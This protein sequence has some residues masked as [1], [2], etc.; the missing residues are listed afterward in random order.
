LEACGN[1]HAVTEDVVAID[2]DVA[3]VDAGA[4]GDAAIPPERPPLSPPSPSVPRP[5]SAQHRPRSRTPKAA[6]PGGLDDA[7]VVLSVRGS[8][9]SRRNAFNAAKVATLVAPHQ[10]GIARYVGRDD[11]C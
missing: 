9:I 4:E 11:C 10:A 6:H 7:S 5:R 1:V 3:N 2:D 8:T